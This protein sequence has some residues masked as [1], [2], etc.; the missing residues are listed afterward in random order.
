[1]SS[2]FEKSR[3]HLLDAMAL[4]EGILSKSNRAF[5]QEVSKY[6]VVNAKEESQLR[7]KLFRKIMTQFLE[8]DFFAWCNFFLPKHFSDVTPDFHYEVVDLLFDLNVPK[9]ALA[10]PRGTSKSTLISV[11]YALFN[12]VTKR[13]PNILIISVNENSAK[14]IVINLKNELTRNERIINFYGN[15]K[16]RALE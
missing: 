3:E 1:M 2:R 8:K 5:E 10:A 14:K 11:A 4:M 13:E 12:I 15:K 6:D 7:D 16:S 9:I